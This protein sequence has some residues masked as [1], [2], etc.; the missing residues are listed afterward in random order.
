[1]HSVLA[2]VTGSTCAGPLDRRLKVHA[3]Q[4][5]QLC[6]L[7]RLDRAAILFALTGV[8]FARAARITS[9]PPMF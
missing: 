3:M 9:R 7:C 2:E 6:Q 8:D 5:W 4:H 1:M